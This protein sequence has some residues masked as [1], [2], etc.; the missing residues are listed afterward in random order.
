MFRK[1]PILLAGSGDDETYEV[2]RERRRDSR[3]SVSVAVG[4]DTVT[5]NE[6]CL[7]RNSYPLYRITVRWTGS[8]HGSFS[9]LSTKNLLLSSPFSENISSTIVS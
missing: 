5:V 2:E 1:G 3:E 4:E 9:I 7:L 6:H 8:G